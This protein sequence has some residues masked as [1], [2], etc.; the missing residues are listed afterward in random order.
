MANEEALESSSLGARRFFG[1]FVRRFEK[2]VPLLPLVVVLFDDLP[3]F[4][5]VS[6]PPVPS[7]F[8]R[9]PDEE[10]APVPEDAAADIGD[11]IDGA[12]AGEESD[13]MPRL[14]LMARWMSS[15]SR[16]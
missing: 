12:V 11:F 14:R 10:P 13:V 3:P 6:A 5:D 16:F 7:L 9:A 8:L 1:F 15:S 4:F 2:P